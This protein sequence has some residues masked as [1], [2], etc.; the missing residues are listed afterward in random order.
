MSFDFDQIVE[1]HFKEKRDIFGF[2]SIVQLIEEAMEQ[3]EAL[4]QAIT[5]AEEGELSREQINL[6]WD[7]IAD[8]AILELPWANPSTQD[9]GA[10][11]DRSARAQ[12]E[13]FLNRIQGT[14][15][16]E[17][18]Q[19][20]ADFYKADSA[21]LQAAGKLGDTKGSEIANIISY[22]T[23]YKTLTKIIAHFNASSAGFSFESFLGVLLG[24]RQIAASGAKTIADI[25]TEDGT[26]VSLKLYN[27]ETLEVSGS[28][29]QL[30]NDLIRGPLYKMQYVVA[31]KTIEGEG[32]ELKGKIHF[33]RFDFT[34]ENVV[35]ILA[36]V[37]RKNPLLIQLPVAFINNPEQFKNIELPEPP[38][39]EELIET[40]NSQL[41]ELLAPYQEERQ[42]QPGVLAPLDIEGL[43]GG[44]NYPKNKEMF[45]GK[46][47]MGVDKIK[48][49]S[50][51]IKDLLD[52]LGLIRG[53]DRFAFITSNRAMTNTRTLVL[54]AI[55]AADQA[56]R[57][58]A[59]AGRTA[60]RQMVDA[61]AVGQKGTEEEGLGF[62]ST[63]KSLEFYNAPERTPEEKIRALLVSRGF[64][65]VDQFQL[66]RP[67]VKNIGAKE[68]ATEGIAVFPEGQEKA[69]IGE[70]NIGYEAVDK[71][72]NDL[73]DILDVTIFN[74]FRDLKELTLNI[75]AFFASG[76]QDTDEKPYATKAIAAAADIEAGTEKA[77]EEFAVKE[78]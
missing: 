43:V 26:P 69:L 42:G 61:A 17:K 13:Q 72:V 34:L 73:K 51:P 45:T 38:A 1:N 21:Q 60:R 36:N 77:A 65:Y 54:Q 41:R 56:V 6:S 29:N 67:E 37:A 76:L 33:Y 58:Q 32:E 39:E 63:Q 71:M 59:Q 20:L 19:S 68:S 49:T 75:Q 46:Q 16:P 24:G 8:L 4:V 31:T 5:E 74:L 66:T 2:D 53:D 78:K 64:V 55:L 44:I 18:L 15:L 22:L 48:L 25:E 23:F 3:K 47:T 14:D 9:G 40:F 12:L 30:V 50:G 27:E 57:Q 70:L 10:E 28:Y 11:L 52:K 35:S 62:A 7:G